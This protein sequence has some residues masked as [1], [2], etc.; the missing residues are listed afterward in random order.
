MSMNDWKNEL[1]EFSERLSPT[2][3]RQQ[4]AM[5]N[6]KLKLMAFFESKVKPAFE[7]FANELQNLGLNVDLRKEEPFTINKIS[8]SIIVFFEGQQEFSC[9]ISGFVL[10]SGFQISI[11][12]ASNLLPER[13]FQ[14]RELSNDLDR[15]AKEDIIRALLAEYKEARTEELQN[16]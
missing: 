2:E 4:S 13:C 14:P 12:S 10:S 16:W 3:L 8:R 9:T 11:Q 5:R 15:T 1:K 6:G 7:E